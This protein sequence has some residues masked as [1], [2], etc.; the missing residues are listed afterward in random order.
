MKENDST[1]GFTNSV[2]GVTD[3]VKPEQ[4]CYAE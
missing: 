4:I 1:A 2:S 3:A